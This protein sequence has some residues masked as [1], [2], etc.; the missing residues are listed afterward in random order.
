MIWKER[1]TGMQELYTYISYLQ[2]EWNNCA[3]SQCKLTQW[4]IIKEMLIIE[5]WKNW[6]REKRMVETR[7]GFMEGECT[8]IYKCCLLPKH[9]GSRW[10]QCII[11]QRKN[12]KVE[13]TRPGLDETKR[14]FLEGT[15]YSEKTKIT[16]W[17]Q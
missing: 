8:C 4:G 7:Y 16:Y 13:E 5:L 1:R 15:V 11:G 9:K 14:N 6:S 3:Q 12:T 17:Y 2:I 10:N